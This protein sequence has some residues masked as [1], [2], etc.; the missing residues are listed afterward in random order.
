MDWGSKMKL[1]LGPKEMITSTDSSSDDESIVTDTSMDGNQAA[2]Q[3]L[4][5]TNNTWNIESPGLIN[6]VFLEQDEEYDLSLSSY[7]ISVSPS[8]E[9]AYQEEINGD[10][11]DRSSENGCTSTR[12]KLRDQRLSSRPMKKDFSNNAG[13]NCSYEI[14]NSSI[15]KDCPPT[16]TSK[17]EEK[18]PENASVDQNAKSDFTISLSPELNALIEEQKASLI[19]EFIDWKAEIPKFFGNAFNLLSRVFGLNLN[20]LGEG[21]YWFGADFIMDSKKQIAPKDATF[22]GLIL[23]E[24][25]TGKKFLV[26]NGREPV[27]LIAGLTEVVT[28]LITIIVYDGGELAMY[29][30]AKPSYLKVCAGPPDLVFDYNE[31]MVFTGIITSDK[32]FKVNILGQDEELRLDVFGQH[33]QVL[34]VD[35]LSKLQK[36]FPVRVVILSIISERIAIMDFNYSYPC[37]IYG[38]FRPEIIDLLIPAGANPYYF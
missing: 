38:K 8:D 36:I 33:C 7:V 32:M 11:T 19:K 22:V 20:T 6:T 34:Y 28:D 18:V 21:A 23:S 17:I 29:N 4:P 15:T 35:Q 26:L 9:E 16:S 24:G 2:T 12:S 25:S 27:Q 30:K 10:V 1:M 13:E 5:L 3:M 31:N 37:N 14:G